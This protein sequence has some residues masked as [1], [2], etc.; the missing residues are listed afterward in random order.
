VTKKM[1][2]ALTILGIVTALLMG[3]GTVWLANE[4]RLFA[5]G[6]APVALAAVAIATYYELQTKRRLEM[7]KTTQLDTES[8]EAQK[9]SRRAA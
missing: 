9:D 6:L 5:L 3:I 8:V 4:V 7:L 2:W 1:T